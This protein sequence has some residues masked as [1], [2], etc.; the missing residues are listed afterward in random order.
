V[1]RDILA[2]FGTATSAET[3]WAGIVRMRRDVRVGRSVNAL[4][5]HEVRQPEVQLLIDLVG[6]D[7]AD[8]FQLAE[9]AL[10]VSG[11]KVIVARE[12]F[13]AN[14]GRRVLF[15]PSVIAEAQQAEK[16]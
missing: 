16:E 2:T 5:P 3:E 6:P 7:D 12:D 13:A 14:A 10:N 15:A 9:Q 4:V 11:R 8:A 1:G